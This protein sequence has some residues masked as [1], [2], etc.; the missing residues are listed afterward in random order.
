MTQ[1]P[2]AENEQPDQNALKIEL[3]KV[4]TKTKE[5]F[6]K[7]V[8]VQKCLNYLG[9]KENYMLEH[10]DPN[11][12]ESLEAKTYQRLKEHKALQPGYDG[13]LVVAPKEEP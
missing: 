6:E 13:S 8:K 4:K 12:K 11:F 5:H 7:E 10:I 1:Y 9:I 3:S 2:H